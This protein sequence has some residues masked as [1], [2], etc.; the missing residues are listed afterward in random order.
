M[1]GEERKSVAIVGGG[2]LGLTV[3][4][5]LAGEGVAVT[6]YERDR[7][8]G[9]LAG[10]T[11]LGGIPVD[12]YYHVVLPTDDRVIGLA[13]ELGLGERLRFSHTGV[14][15]WHAGRLTS[16]SSLRELLTFPS[17]RPIDRVRL[18]AFVARCQLISDHGPLDQEPLETWLRR[19][20]GDQLWERLWRPLLDSK[21]DGR[22]DDLP[23][24]YLWARTRRMSKTRDRSSREVMGTIDGGY[25]ALVDRLGAAIRARGGEVLA[26]RPVRA[27]AA[28]SGQAIGVVT[29]DGFRG[30]DQVL[31]TLLPTQRSALLGDDLAEAVGPDHVRYLGVV[32]LLLRLRGSLSPYYALNITDRR[33]PLTTV[34]ETTHVVDPERVGGTLV[35]VPK[36]VNPDSPELD[37]SNREIRD[38]YFGHLRQIFPAVGEQD[39]LA[40]QVAR[41][42]TAEPVH[43][44]DGAGRTPELFPAPGL[45][46]ASTANIYPELVNGQA[47]IGIADRM[48]SALLERLRAT[49]EERRAA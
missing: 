1:I 17:L 40:W 45:A 13:A 6:V 9:G 5:R 3:A 8:L 39:V 44:L 47:V 46:V 15:F 33:C 10:Q 22:F 11:N 12:R 34:V 35:Y 19:M 49:H 24:S 38:A 31:C 20:C 41:A 43:T 4:Y 21:F 26:G 27:I 18:G 7:T 23:A 16:M 2:L 48:S 14:G 25:Q 28:A 42:R 30:F 36:Y 29:D 32:C 37:R